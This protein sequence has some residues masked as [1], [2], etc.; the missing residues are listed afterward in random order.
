MLQRTLFRLFIFYIIILLY[1]CSYY[2]KDFILQSDSVINVMFKKYILFFSLSCSC[3]KMKR[4]FWLMEQKSM[5]FPVTSLNSLEIDTAFEM[6]TNE[7]FFRYHIFSCRRYRV[8]QGLG[9]DFTT[10]LIIL[11]DLMN[12]KKLIYFLHNCPK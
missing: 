8:L 2:S 12:I 6:V 4:I 10:H 11:D 7:Q 9:H 5:L 3:T 1:Y